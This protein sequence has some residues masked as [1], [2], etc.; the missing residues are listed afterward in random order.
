MIVKSRILI[1]SNAFT[2]QRSLPTAG[3]ADNPVRLSLA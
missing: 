3:A 2:V 1:H